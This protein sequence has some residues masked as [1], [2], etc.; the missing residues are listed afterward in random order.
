MIEEGQA[1]R[2]SG[3]ARARGYWWGMAQGAEEFSHFCTGLR[4]KRWLQASVA[5]GESQRRK[6]RDILKQ[7]RRECVRYRLWLRFGGWFEPHCCISHGK[8]KA[9]LWQECN[10]SLLHTLLEISCFQDNRDILVPFSRIPLQYESDRKC[11]IIIAL[12][13]TVSPYLDTVMLRMLR[14]LR[15]REGKAM[16]EGFLCMSWEFH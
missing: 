5:N 2:I 8:S 13:R 12:N 16:F 10:V 3:V 1:V 15:E 14:T 4:R 11:E 6:Q 9:V 7:Q